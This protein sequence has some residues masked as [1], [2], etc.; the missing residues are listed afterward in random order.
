MPSPRIPTGQAK[1]PATP[2]TPPATATPG[3]RIKSRA[4]DYSFSRAVLA[5]GL[6]THDELERVKQELGKTAAGGEED[7]EKQ[8]ASQ[9]VQMKVLTQ[10]QADQLLA[11][12]TKFSLGPY[13]ITDWLGQGGMGQVFKAIHNVMGRESAVKVLPLDKSTPYAIANFIRE[14]RT[15]A[16]LDHPHLVRAYDAG[17]DGNVH[18]LVTEYVPGTDLRQL[19]RSQ[20]PLEMSQAASVIMQ[21]A[22]GLDHAHQQGLIHRDVKPGNVMVTPKGVAKVSDLGLAGFVHAADDDPRSGKIVGTADYLPPEQIR[23]PTDITPSS[24]IYSLGCTLYYAITGK[25]PYPG[26][27]TNDKA[28]R[29]LHDH[30]WHPRRF[31]N[32]I[33]EEFVEIIAELMEKDPAKRI[34]SCAEVVSRLE[35]FAENLASLPAQQL[36]S[37]PWSSPPLPG[38]EETLVEGDGT[39]SRSSQTAIGTDPL[40]AGSQ[41]TDSSQLPAAPPLALTDLGPT[42]IWEDSQTWMIVGISLA[43]GF[44]IGFLFTIT[45]GGIF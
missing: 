44:V 19:V 34:G 24:D 17:H 7:L 45:L 29:H 10:Y 30:P 16:Q 27:S 41:E 39:G 23:N 31:N 26:G 11:G 5:S 2:E 4:K 33:S 32:S 25:V 8:L 38:Q 14:I 35:P 9:F 40:E 20:G 3:R 1:S 6:V 15:Q 42:S 21:A 13:I 37:S 22:M 43:V 12:Q 36:V 28:H 18:Y